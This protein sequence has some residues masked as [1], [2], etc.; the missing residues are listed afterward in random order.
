MRVQF[1]REQA[2]AVQF[3]AAARASLSV[4]KFRKHGASGMW[5]D[6]HRWALTRPPPAGAST[7]AEYS[8]LPSR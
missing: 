3:I 4:R 5:S 1:L 7:D 8:K 2:R 6:T